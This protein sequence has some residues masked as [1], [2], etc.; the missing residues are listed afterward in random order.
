MYILLVLFSTIYHLTQYSGWIYFLE[1]M[2]EKHHSITIIV[3]NIGKACCI[4]F[5]SVFFL[6][7]SKD[8]SQL[9][10]LELGLLAV[11]M[12]AVILLG[13]PES[14]KYYHM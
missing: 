4:I 8:E 1:I 14:P 12:A 2:P 3:S 6:H 7:L 11:M 9:F 13:L 5:G 10:M